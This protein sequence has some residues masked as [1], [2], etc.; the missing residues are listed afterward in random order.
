VNKY[1]YKQDQN[2]KQRPRPRSD[3]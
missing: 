1:D 2:V 3:V